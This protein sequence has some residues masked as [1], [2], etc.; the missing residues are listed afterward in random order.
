L[1]NFLS[2]RLVQV[3]ALV[4]ILIFMAAGSIYW[5]ADRAEGYELNGRAYSPVAPAPPLD[6]TDQHGNPFSLAQEAGKVAVVS[7]GSTRCPDD[8]PTML[9]DF[10]TI[11]S[12]LGDHAYLVDFLFVTFDPETDTQERMTDAI[13]SVDPSFIGLRGDDEQTARI[14]DA[15]D[16][17][18]ERND[19]ASSS[20]GCHF[21][22]NARVYLIDK[23][24]N[25]RVTYV[26]GTDP[27]KIA[28]DIEHL[29]SE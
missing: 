26:P 25:L 27:L 3:M 8:G 1:K 7:F 24:G 4:T 23:N 22:D 19:T 6:L 28:Q 14:L 17:T 12:N 21:E 29:A 15:Y 11:R 2:Q 5:I 10:A 18:I 16:M 9:D 20:T 13:A